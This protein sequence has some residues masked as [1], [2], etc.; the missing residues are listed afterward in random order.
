M[1]NTTGKKFGG[2]KKGTPNKTTKDLRS[3]L[4]AF[5]ENK[6]QQIEKDWHKLTPSQR[7]NLFER[8]LKFVL[9][10]LQSAELKTDFEKLS[11]TDVD[12]LL[13]EIYNNASGNKN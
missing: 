2:R 6:Q 9:P 3:W 1:A 4:T 13:N 12:K 11:D 8:L 7:I 10:T 5:L